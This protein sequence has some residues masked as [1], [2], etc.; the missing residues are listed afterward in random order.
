MR[1]EDR[2]ELE[3]SEGCLICLT[4]VKAGR[5]HSYKCWL[6]VCQNYVQGLEST[7]DITGSIV[8]LSSSANN[9]SANYQS[10]ISAAELVVYF[11]QA[12]SQSSERNLDGI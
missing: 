5:G 7:Y 10:T 1:I 9:M 8:H 2:V 4:N 12:T 3:C 11:T 6:V